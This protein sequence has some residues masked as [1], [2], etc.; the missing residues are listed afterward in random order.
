MEELLNNAPCGYVSF[1]DEGII[2][3]CNN[4]LASL[5][6]FSQE[7]LTGKKFESLL[8]VAGRIFF[9][10]HIFPL[11]KIQ[12]RADEIF[13]SILTKSGGLIPVLTNTVRQNEEGVMINNCILI[14]VL[15]RR[16]YEDEILAAKRIAEETLKENK[17]LIKARQEIEFHSKALDK[18]LNKLNQFNN[19]WV[20]INKIVNH[21][22]QEC[23]RKIILFT[24]IAKDKNDD[25]NLG[26]VLVAAE[27]L[28]SIN[29]SLESYMTLG[30]KEENFSTVNLKEVVKEAIIEVQQE[31]NFT[32]MQVSISEL[33]NITGSAYQLKIFFA[34]VLSNAI[35]FRKGDSLTI[36]IEHVIYES[37]LYRNSKEKYD[38]GEL[39]RI[40]LQD[41]GIGFDNQYKDYVFQILKKMDTDG[42]RG[43]GF[44]LAICKKVV[45]NH[46]GEISISSVP[47][48]G[49]TVSIILPVK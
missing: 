34:Q 13:F 11:V 47:G 46:R 38:Y 48:V 27:R 5:L 29:K 32:D 36:S 35:H 30:F 10:T 1:T 2:K 37:N 6:G 49:T 33:P 43:L 39:I 21:D 42:D 3:R 24:N 19:E 15:Q 22:M 23:I 12:N 14:P 16:K 40:T 18:Q 44:G 17:E 4:T 41:D 20:E 31:T 8:S 45:E 9:Q 25:R 26:K 28:K 7:E